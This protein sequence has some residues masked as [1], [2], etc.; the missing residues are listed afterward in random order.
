MEREPATH[1]HEHD[2]L[3]CREEPRAK[4]AGNTFSLALCMER[5]ST[6]PVVMEGR[7]L[8]AA[9]QVTKDSTG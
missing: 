6:V 7:H 9:S 8:Y 1:S 3:A 5:A 4:F 2:K